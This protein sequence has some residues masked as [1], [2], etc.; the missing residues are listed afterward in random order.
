MPGQVPP[1]SGRRAVSSR[2][3]SVTSLQLDEDRWSTA[4]YLCKKIENLE[5]NFNNLREENNSLAQTNENLTKAISTLSE[6]YS[7]IV[8]DQK[9]ILNL[10]KSLQ[11]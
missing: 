8:K 11:N 1:N 6:E 4:A 7:K 3:A 10:V 9:E 5:K 2:G